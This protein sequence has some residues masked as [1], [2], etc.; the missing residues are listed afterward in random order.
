MAARALVGFVRRPA[1]DLALNFEDQGDEGPLPRGI[2]GMAGEAAF[3]CLQA[4]WRHGHAPSLAKD[5]AG[6]PGGQTYSEVTAEVSVSGFENTTRG[7]CVKEIVPIEIYFRKITWSWDQATSVGWWFHDILRV[8]PEDMLPY[9]LRHL[10][11][12]RVQTQASSRGPG[13][14]DPRWGSGRC[15]TMKNPHY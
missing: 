14:A 11:L 6:A 7:V 3:F 10:R 4:L 2:A 5:K 9:I 1:N 12:Q 8:T 15:A 13:H